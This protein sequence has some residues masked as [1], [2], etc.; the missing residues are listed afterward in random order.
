[1]G[2]PAACVQGSCAAGGDTPRQREAGALF[3]RAADALG[4]REDKEP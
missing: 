3:Q 4:Q 1:M 2:G